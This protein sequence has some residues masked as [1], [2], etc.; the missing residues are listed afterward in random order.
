MMV[1]KLLPLFPRHREY[2]E[3]FFGGGSLFFAKAPAQIE[4]INDLDKAVVTFFRVLR[5]KPQEFLRLAKLTPYSRDLHEECVATWRFEED[6]VRRAWRWWVVTRQ[7]F[8]GRFGATWG[9]EVKQSSQGMS[10]SV[11]AMKNVVAEL[12]LVSRRLLRTQIEN[13]PA[14][15]VLQNCCTKTSLAYVDPPYVSSE[16]SFGSY[17]HE[18]TDLDHAELVETIL[19]LPGRFVVSGYASRL[20]TPLERAGWTRMDFKTSCHAAGRTRG[21]GLQG[22]GAV[23]EKQQRIETVWLDPRT[24]REVLTVDTLA[25]LTSRGG[26]VAKPDGGE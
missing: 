22:E 17:E 25:L 23:L 5:D 7:S 19:G 9:F 15:R 10:S 6:E 21:T 14:L 8:A 13:Q 24:A 26:M 18:M 16:R 3:P 20:Y 4:T 11:A 12:P 1:A 2:V